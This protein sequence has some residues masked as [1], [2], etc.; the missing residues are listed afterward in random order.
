M[1]KFKF[2]VRRANKRPFYFTS[3]AATWVFGFITLAVAYFLLFVI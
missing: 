3:V 2:L 1:N